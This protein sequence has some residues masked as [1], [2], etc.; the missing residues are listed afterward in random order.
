[1]LGDGLIQTS[2][3]R[4]KKSARDHPRQG[5]TSSVGA[6][7]ALGVVQPGQLADG[8]PVT[9]GQGMIGDERGEL[10][11]PQRA[12]DL[13]AA[14]RVG[15]VEH[16]DVLARLPGRLQDQAERRDVGVEPGP[17]VLDVVDQDVDPLEVPRLGLAVLARRG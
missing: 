4:S 14:D 3:V 5:I 7:L 1:M 6:D 16:H 17:D 10:L 2:P 8:H 11:V 13:A 12:G 9:D 15:A